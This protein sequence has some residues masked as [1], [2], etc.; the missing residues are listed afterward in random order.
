LIINGNGN[1]SNQ[2]P[3]TSSQNNFSQ[4]NRNWNTSQTPSANQTQI[5]R[6]QQER[7]D[8]STPVQRQ[9]PNYY[10]PPAQTPNSGY[11][12]DKRIY[13]PKQQQIISQE[14]NHYAPPAAPVERPQNDEPRRNYSP[15][16]P[17]AAAPVERQQNNESHQN[18]SPPAAPSAPA[19]N[20]NNS[21]SG[22]Q[23]SGRQDW[24]QNKPG[25]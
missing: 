21:S 15:P 2:R 24:N 4:P 10:S 20:N 3:E 18:Y 13:A 6:G 5:Q 9:A 8:V 16:A 19:G 1:N 17:P 22:S 11:D 14:P 25:H 7:T 23:Q 12:P